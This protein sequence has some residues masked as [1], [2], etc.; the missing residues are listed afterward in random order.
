MTIFHCVK[1]GESRGVPPSATGKIFVVLL[2]NV[3]LD[4][5]TLTL[6]KKIKANLS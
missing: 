6:M 1:S 5:L 2:S 3:I 4:L